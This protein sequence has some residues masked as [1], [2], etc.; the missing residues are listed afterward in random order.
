VWI[1]QIGVSAQAWIAAPSS[2][3]ESRHRLVFADG[4]TTQADL[5]SNQALMA[6]RNGD[7]SI[8]SRQSHAAS[9]ASRNA[10][11]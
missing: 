9:S 4:S 6:Q 2:G 1:R 3:N 7:A 11:L 5:R 8:R 10:V